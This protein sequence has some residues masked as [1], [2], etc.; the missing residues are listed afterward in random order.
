MRTGNIMIGAT[1]KSRKD[2][3]FNKE[4]LRIEKKML[5]EI[6]RKQRMAENR[7]P[8][9]QSILK[10]Q[11]KLLTNSIKKLNKQNLFSKFK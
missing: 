3:K 5:A 11:A 7:N 4:Q 6:R 10:E 8:F 1:V 2:I 9:S